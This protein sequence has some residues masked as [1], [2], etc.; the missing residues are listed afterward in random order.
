M[1]RA[2]IVEDV[3][4]TRDWL[5]E[6]TEKAFP[7][8]EIHEC[9]NVREGL[10]DVRR[11]D[12]DLALID[13]GLPDGNGSEIVMAL[14]AKGTGTVTVVATV[15]GDDAS[16]LAALSA[17][18][19]GYLLKDSP[20]EVFERQLKQIEQGVPALSPSIARRILAHFTSTFQADEPDA[21]LTPRE[22][23]VLGLI[24]RGLRNSD[25]ARSL[26]LSESTVASH[27]KSIYAKL[28]ISSRAEAALE[29]ARLGLTK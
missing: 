28:G 21:N 5:R 20:A 11:F 19:S 15:M 3:A 27:I 13:L 8:C 16:V 29:A 26:G 17:G 4:E 6:I 1:K 14:T 12:F 22:R 10:F 2:L 24:G 18:A 25:A 23:D 7:D 9:R